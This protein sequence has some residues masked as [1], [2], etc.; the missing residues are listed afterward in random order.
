MGLGPFDSI[1]LQTYLPISA[2]SVTMN[3]PEAPA[4]GG[5]GGQFHPL[6]IFPDYAFWQVGGGHDG[7]FIEADFEQFSDQTSVSIELNVNSEL[8]GTVLL[9]KSGSGTIRYSDGTQQSIAA[10]MLLD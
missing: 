8:I 2:A 4:G 5:C 10:W 1:S 6:S 3:A 9:D 7:T